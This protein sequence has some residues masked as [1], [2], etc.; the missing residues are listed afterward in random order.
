MLGRGVSLRIVRI[1]VAAVLAYVLL[2]LTDHIVPHSWYLNIWISNITL[3][4]ELSLMGVIMI[5]L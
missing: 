4:L 3:V 1:I 2:A 5:L